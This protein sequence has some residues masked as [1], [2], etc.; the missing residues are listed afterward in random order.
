MI[1]DGNGCF[2]RHGPTSTEK[3]ASGAG[4]IFTRPFFSEPSTPLRAAGITK[5]AGCHSLRHSFATHL[6]EAGYDIRSVQKLL[7]HSELET[8]MMYVHLARIGSF[9]VRSPL[10]DNEDV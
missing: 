8:T 5:P 2:P 3:R 1:G 10:D 9:R 4:T 7:G 6:V